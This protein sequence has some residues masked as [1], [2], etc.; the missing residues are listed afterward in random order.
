MKPLRIRWQ[1]YTA[2]LSHVIKQVKGCQ[3]QNKAILAISRGGLIPGVALSHV[4]YNTAFDIVRCVGYAGELQLPK[5]A[6]YPPLDYTFGK[7]PIDVLV[8]DDLIDTGRTLLAVSDWL[9]SLGFVRAP[10]SP[11]KESVRTRQFNIA[12][13]YDKVR[14]DRTIAADIVGRVL[15][16]DRWV[17]FPYEQ[18]DS[19]R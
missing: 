19:D 3:F 14:T 17:T 7:A 9:T 5:V 12:V 13:V 6:L 8:V 16:A 18:S 4:S 10:L 1:E 11:V 2:A 15:P